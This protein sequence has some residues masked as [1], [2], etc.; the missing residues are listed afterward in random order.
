[1][2]FLPISM[3]LVIHVPCDTIEYT[4]NLNMLYECFPL[5]RF[6]CMIT[7]IYLIITDLEVDT[8][9]FKGID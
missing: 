9:R 3:L 5:G 7:F 6:Q 4:I 2:M 1:M 8:N